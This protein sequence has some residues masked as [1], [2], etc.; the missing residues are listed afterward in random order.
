MRDAKRWTPIQPRAELK[1]EWIHKL[2]KE[3]L[4]RCSCF[5]YRDL[6]S[7]AFSAFGEEKT[8]FWERCRQACIKPDR[9]AKLFCASVLEPQLEVTDLLRP[10]SAQG[11]TR[12][13]DDSGAKWSLSD[14]TEHSQTP[15]RLF[16]SGAAFDR[17][18]VLL[19]QAAFQMPSLRTLFRHPKRNPNRLFLKAFLAALVRDC[20]VL[21]TPQSIPRWQSTLINLKF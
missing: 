6:T 2:C 10:L 8:I 21:R 17:S 9:G 1:F 3:L 13:L 20:Q 11:G 18:L 19:Q 16:N 7:G 4:S 14:I 12:S 15:G 5:F